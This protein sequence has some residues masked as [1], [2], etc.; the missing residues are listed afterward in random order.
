VRLT[1]FLGDT[2]GT[3]RGQKD[4]FFCPLMRTEEKSNSHT[5]LNLNAE[6]ET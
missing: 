3:I 4:G 6:G 5:P 2:A 1:K